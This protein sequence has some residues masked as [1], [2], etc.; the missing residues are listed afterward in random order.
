MHHENA[1]QSSRRTLKIDGLNLMKILFFLIKLC[2]MWKSWA[3]N[4]QGVVNGPFDKALLKCPAWNMEDVLI[5]L[6]IMWEGI[7]INDE[8]TEICPSFT[9]IIPWTGLSSELTPWAW[10]TPWQNSKMGYDK[11]FDIFERNYTLKL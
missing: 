5:Y 6:K 3:S 9:W 1:F 8:F 7:E 4:I 11:K 10:Y 2:W